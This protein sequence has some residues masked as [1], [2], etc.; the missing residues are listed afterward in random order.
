MSEPG[1]EIAS[2]F[3]RVQPDAAD[4]AAALDEQVGGLALSVVVTPNTSDFAAAMDD[5][6]GGLSLSVAVT[7]DMSDFASAV[8]EQGGGLTLP[9]TIT[10]DTTDLAAAVDEQGLTA[11]VS[12]IPD[13]S[14]AADFGDAVNE[15]TGTIA[16]P[17]RPIP[18]MADFEADLGER[19]GGIT[20]PVGVYPAVDPSDFQDQLT[21]EIGTPVVGVDVQASLANMAEHLAD[22]FAGA[23][24]VPVV[25]NMSDFSDAVQEEAAGIS[26]SVGVVPD[27]ASLDALPGEIQDAVGAE[28]IVIP[29]SVDTGTAVDSLGQLAQAEDDAAAEASSATGQYSALQEQFSVLEGELDALN[30]RFGVL[31]GGMAS[32][33]EESSSAACVARCREQPVRGAGRVRLSRSA[34]SCPGWAAT[35]PAPGEQIGLLSSMLSELQAS[36]SAADDAVSC[37]GTARSPR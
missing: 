34:P 14:G 10:P 7:P 19:A 6:L 8:D 28:G 18:E 26:V 12:L 13:T 11:S 36:L 25:P 3:V 27:G 24:P 21:D 2:A 1:F 37:S 35:F 5:A 16:V 4:F 32:A 17:V 9:V 33:S 20:V 30:T 22:S 23:I 31:S 15:Q 29:V